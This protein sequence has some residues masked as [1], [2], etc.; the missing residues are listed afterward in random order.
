FL[1]EFIESVAGGTD[2]QL[3]SIISAY[4]LTNFVPA[5][6]LIMFHSEADAWV[7]VRN[8]LNTYDKMKA[9][10]APVRKDILPLSAGQSHQDAAETFFLSVLMNILLTGVIN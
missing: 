3:L 2:T 5:D 8:T 1:P 7:P 10:N 6:S 9:A 4:S